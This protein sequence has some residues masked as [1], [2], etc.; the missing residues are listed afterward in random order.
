MTLDASLSLPMLLAL[1]A[2]HGLNPGMGWLFAVA[3]GLQEQDRAAVWR[4]L[5]PLAVGHG[6]AIGAAVAVAALLGLV[7]PLPALRALIGVLLLALGLWSLLRHRHLRWGGMRV[8]PRQLATW[9]FLM[10]T[11]HGAGLMALPFVLGTAAAAP[12]GHEAHAAHAAHL[13]R[14]G[15]LSAGQAAGATAVAVHALGYL[16]ITGLLAVIVYEWA[17]LRLLRTAWLN[18]DRVWA[19]ALVVTAALVLAG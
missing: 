4:A 11:A 12:A 14:A 3:L 15:M 18:L 8:G 19:G 9:S 17:G 2:L 10:A 7:V 16:A 1:G 6:L 5:G 13:A